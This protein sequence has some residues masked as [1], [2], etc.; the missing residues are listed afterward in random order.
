MT[1]NRYQEEALRTATVNAKKPLE[2]LELARDAL[3]V[4]GEAGEVADLVK[5]HVGHGHPLDPDKVKKELGDVLWYV[6]VLAERCGF[7][8]EDVAR[9]N[10]EKLRKRYPKGFDP[11]RSKN[12]DEG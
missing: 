12:R 3:G 2:P 1:L 5:K 8:L 9:A 4:A 6:A 11:E 7:S 10:V